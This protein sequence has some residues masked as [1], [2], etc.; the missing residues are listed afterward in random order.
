MCKH[1]YGYCQKTNEATHALQEVYEE[2]REFLVLELTRPLLLGP[3]CNQRW[4]FNMDQ[5]PLYVSYYSSRTLEKHGT[6]TIHVRKTSNRTKRATGAFTISPAGD[7]LGPIII[8]KGKP[9]GRIEKK[10]LPKFNPSSMYTCQ[11]A[12]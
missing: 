8:F 9:G 12:A 5:T 2:A 4:I 11:K 1:N 6:K 10:E 3:H 7:F